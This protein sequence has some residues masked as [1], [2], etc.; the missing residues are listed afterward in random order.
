MRIRWTELASS[1]IANSYEFIAED[2]P[3][4]ALFTIENLISYAELLLTHPRLGREAKHGTR[5]L[6]HPPFIIVYRILDDVISIEAVF[7]GSRRYFGI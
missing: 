3:D 7:H 1:H 5:K 6:T 4:A 2:K